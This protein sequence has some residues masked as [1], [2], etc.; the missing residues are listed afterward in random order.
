MEGRR[1][2]ER[3]ELDPL[4]E[5][6]TAALVEG[7]LAALL[8]KVPIGGYGRRAAAMPLYAREL[9]VAALDS[10]VLHEVGGLGGCPSNRH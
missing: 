6:D 3:L 9:V 7:L 10:G 8:S 1:A 2:A 4:G 5:S